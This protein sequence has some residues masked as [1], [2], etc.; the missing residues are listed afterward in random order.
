MEPEATVAGILL[1]GGSSRRMGGYDK[2]SIRINGVPLAVRVTGVLG[3]V[4]SPVIEVGPGR[5]GGTVVEE[6]CPGSG[7]L[8]AIRDGIRGLRRA[9]H[10]GDALVLA[11]DLPLASEVALRALTS[12]PVSGSVVPLIG[13][14]P[15]PLCARWSANDLDAVEA[16]VD[17]GARAM[18][19]LLS[20]GEVTLVDEE[21]WPAVVD[22]AAF[23][24]AD[25]PA[26]FD[27]LGLHWRP[28][29]GGR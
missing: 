1:T 27:A 14:R 11:C 17:A 13:G 4:A 21:S 28:Q 3:R 8:V 24:D 2:P 22:V 25:T 12:W 20:R 6:L 18:T 7:P 19:A 15:Q 9:G 10:V 5:S 26:D 23:V 16:L 29:A